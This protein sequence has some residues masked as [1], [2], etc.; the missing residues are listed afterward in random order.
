VLHMKHSFILC[1]NLDTSG[2]RSEIPEKLWNV[3]LETDGDQ[4]DLSCAK[5]SVLHG[6]KE[7]VSHM[8]YKEG[9]L[10]GWVTSC[11]K[12]AFYNVLLKE[13]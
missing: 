4:L 9:R 8:Q 12:T 10:T 5:W 7:G 6:V 11:I 1:W 13:G 2:S 3:L